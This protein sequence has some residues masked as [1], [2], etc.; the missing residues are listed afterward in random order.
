MNSTACK[1]CGNVNDNN[2]HFVKEM[3]LGL[4]EEFKYMECA[5]CK[6][7]VLIDIPIDFSKYYPIEKYYSFNNTKHL[8][9][10]NFFKIQLLN[11][12]LKYYIGSLNFIGK[13]LSFNYNLN[14]KYAWI[15]HLMNIPFNATILDIGSGTGKYL[16]ELYHL[17]FRNITGIDPYNASII[18]LNKN[19]T[20]YNYELEKLT[21]KYDLILMNHSLEHM[22]DHDHVFKELNRLLNPG[23]KILIRIPFIGQAWEQ[24]GI[25]WYQIDAP[26][27]TIIHSKNSFSMLCNRNNFKIDFIKHDSNDYQFKFSEQYSNNLTIFENGNFSKKTYKIWRTRATELNSNQKGDQVSI[28]ISKAS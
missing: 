15:S 13:F 9:V 5:N 2:F 7:L 19:I 14:R 8:K 1:I 16:E 12:L 6:A 24:Y 25:H 17:G 11:Q 22:I 23:G 27:H 4:R 18:H 10:V 28:M 26:R 3:M 20:I 21:T